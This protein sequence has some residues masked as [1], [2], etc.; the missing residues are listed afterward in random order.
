M[1]E[2]KDPARMLDEGSGASTQLRSLLESAVREDHPPAP[3][4]QSVDRAV[5]PLLGAPLAP[6]GTLKAAGVLASSPVVKWGVALLIASA[7]G[8][9]GYLL[10]RAKPTAE[11]APPL[12]APSPAPL[13]PTVV[14]PAEPA[15]E[16]KPNRAEPPV[17]EHVRVH[18]RRNRVPLTLPS[19]PDVAQEV[20]LLRRA[21]EALLAGA[22]AQA[23]TLTDDHARAFPKG[24]LVQEREVIAI[25]ALL[26]L[27]R[28]E[29]ALQRVERFRARFPGSAHLPRIEQLLSA[30]AAP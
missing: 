24:T 27:G 28:R 15:V 12:A 7:L 20:L 25:E 2:L 30:E 14:A 22:P 1:N 11:L 3:H 13:A 16:Q 5:A 4:T 18:R 6:A 21:H 8:T 26:D 19:G 17:A 9:T 23:L 29:V 10:V